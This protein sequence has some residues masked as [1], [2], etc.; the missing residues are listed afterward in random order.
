M[1]QFHHSRS[2]FGGIFI[3]WGFSDL[4]AC[5]H[6]QICLEILS[7]LILGHQRIHEADSGSEACPCAPHSGSPPPV[8]T[9]SAGR[10]CF[11]WRS[12]FELTSGV[13]VFFLIVM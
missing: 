8:A 1:S 11:G 5:S 13:C 10:F 3:Q 6:K 2:R 4:Q 9:V 12:W 7:I